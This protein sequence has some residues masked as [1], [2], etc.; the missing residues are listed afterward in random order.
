MFGRV[1]A[2]RKEGDLSSFV[3]GMVKENPSLLCVNCGK[4]GVSTVEKEDY[5]YHV[6]NACRFAWSFGSKRGFK[7]HGS[8]WKFVP[9]GR[10]WITNEVPE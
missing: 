10:M 6:C 1:V 9:E 2:W 3:P 8:K 4:A 5:I 7:K